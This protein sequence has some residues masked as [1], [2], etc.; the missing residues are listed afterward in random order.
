MEQATRRRYLIQSLL[1]ENPRTTKFA[2]PESKQAQ[3]K[4]L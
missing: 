3:E 2:I 4:M 1:N